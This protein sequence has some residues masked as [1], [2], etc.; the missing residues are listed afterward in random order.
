MI[1]I[2]VAILLLYLGGN[3]YLFLRLWQAMQHTPL[4]C[5]VLL[6]ILFIVAA[7]SLFIAMALRHASL[8]EWLHRALFSIG[9]VWLIF[10]LYMVLATALF[11]VAHLI[12][13]TLKHGVW[14]ALSATTILLI[15]GYVNY[16]HP[17]VEHA[18]VPT[19]KHI[20]GESYRIVMISDIHLGHGTTKRDLER[21]VEL[22][23]RQRGDV[24][25]IVGDL[26]DNSI[27]PVVRE[28]MCR[29]FSH[30]EARDGIY[31][32][33]G[34]HEYISG[35]D[36]CIKYLNST[37]IKLL[38]DSITTLPSGIQLVGRDDRSNRG[39]ATLDSL[40]RGVDVS[41]PTIVLDHQPY[42]IDECVAA[43]VDIYLAGHTHRGQVWPLNWVTD[44]MYA[45]SHGYKR[46]QESHV[47]VSS[48][49]SLWGPP[50]RIGTHSDL[51]VIEIRKADKQ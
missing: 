47:I 18:T 33:A 46:W 21:Y 45:Q 48:G 51:Y 37:N 22:I 9:S 29:L 34:N 38:R 26:I 14:L 27:L 36:A 8:P 13:P 24:V 30:I 39:R 16:R 40:M 3:T 35:I 44:A 1:W 4:W 10:L 49:L 50:F 41:R 5:R 17:R 15:Y 2:G 23:N 6:A 42:A 12:F 31:M 25:F 43:N 7:L 28:D 32:V 11:D 20:E 19:T